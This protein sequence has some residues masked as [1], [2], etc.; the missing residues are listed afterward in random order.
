M[1][2]SLGRQDNAI[3]GVDIV[4]EVTLEGFEED[5]VQHKHQVI[6][7]KGLLL[8][9]KR[10]G[11]LVAGRKVP[12][13]GK[14]SYKLYIDQGKGRIINEEYCELRKYRFIIHRVKGL[15]NSLQKIVGYVPWVG[16][17]LEKITPDAK[18]KVD[19]AYS[20]DVGMDK[21]LNYRVLIGRIKKPKKS[22]ISEGQFQL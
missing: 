5:M 17:P 13:N 2:T 7:E 15:Y 16:K 14:V 11:V 19:V 18:Q 3:L 9:L 6:A 22:I 10:E 8:P 20:L 4:L 12:V 21:N 1:A